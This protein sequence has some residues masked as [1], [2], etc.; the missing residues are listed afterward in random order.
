MFQHYALMSYALTC[1]LLTDLSA[2]ATSDAVR[3][4]LSPRMWRTL[5]VDVLCSER[6]PQ[7]KRKQE[8]RSRQRSGMS[9]D[10]RGSVDTSL[11][12]G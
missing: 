5:N 9:S 4:A 2:T 8:R 3:P 7:R 12:R 11:Y 6:G 10:R 1:A